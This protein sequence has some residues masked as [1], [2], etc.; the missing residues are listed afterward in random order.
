[1]EAAV[2]YLDAPV[3]Y[4]ADCHCCEEYAAYVEEETGV[5]VDIAE[6]E[7]LSE[8]KA[9]HGVPEEMAAC[10]T[11]DIGDYFV[12]GHVPLEAIGKLADERP[13][14]AGISLPGMPQGSPGMTGTKDEEWTIFAVLDDG[15]YDEFMLI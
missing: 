15:S 2:A 12:E 6:V 9:N 1:M 3:L 4:T 14:I 10:H 11:M 5:I 8:I 7:D 13:A